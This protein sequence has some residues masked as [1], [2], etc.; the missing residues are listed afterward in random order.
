M[1]PTTTVNV[2][3]SNYNGVANLGNRVIVSLT[4]NGNFATPS[5]TLLVLQA[6]TT[7]VEAAIAQWGPVGNRGSHADLLDLR[8][9]VNVLYNDLLAEAQY[10]Q[11][12]AQLAAGTDYATMA[13]IITTSGFGVKNPPVPQ[14]ILGAPQNLHR[15][16]KNSISLYTPLLRWKKPI[17]LTS[18]NNV[19]SYQILRNTVNNLLTATVIGTSTKVEFLDNT[20]L[21]GTQYFYWVKGVNTDGAGAESAVLSTSTPV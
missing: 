16:F 9:K 4:G 5:P 15:F 3:K 21:A 12:T 14:G 19:K 10:V 8:Q 7:A 13:A 2:K 17:G 6:D 20:A 18:P 11:N 1:K